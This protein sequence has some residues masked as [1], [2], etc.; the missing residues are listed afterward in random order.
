MNSPKAVSPIPSKIP[1]ILDTDIGDDIDDT[2][3]L[4]MLLKSPELDLKMIVTDFGNTTYRA[5]LVA[6]LLQIAERTDI[7]IGIGLQQTD[8]TGAQAEWLDGYTLADY[9]GTVHQDGVGAMIDMI[10]AAPEPVTLL[11]IGPVP[12]ISAALAREPRIVE[13]VRIVGMYG[14]VRKGYNGRSQ[15]DP[16]YN[17]Y[18]DVAACRQMFAAFPDVTITPV[19]TCGLV[20]LDGSDY[21]KIVAC[22]DPLIQALIENNHIWAK[23]VTWTHVDTSEQSSVLFD[24]VAVYLVFAEELLKIESLGI[25]ITDDGVTRINDKAKAIRVATEWHDLPAFNRFLVKRLTGTED[26]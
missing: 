22:P 2:W 4:A 18:S 26:E 20:R 23:H 25:E 5:T 3:A 15:V 19:D 21:Q 16:E 8:K 7:P 24:T 1:V 10:M 9:P 14:S 13:K 11:C 12:N 6:K 17:V